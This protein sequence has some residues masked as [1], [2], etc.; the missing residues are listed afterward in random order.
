M[1]MDTQAGF[2]APDTVAGFGSHAPVTVLK[3]ERGITYLIGPDGKRVYLM[4]ST[5]GYNPA[6]HKI[7][8]NPNTPH[9][10]LISDYEWDTATGTFK[11]KTN[12]GNVIALG[13]GA[14]IAAPVAM[15]AFGAGA[16]SSAAASGAL[17]STSI[18]A[19][20]TMSAVAPAITGT[21]AAAAGT[22]AGAG[23][24]AAA[25]VGAG[26]MAGLNARDWLDLALFGGKTVADFAGANMTA[27]ASDKASEAQ[28]QAAREGLAL[29]KQEYD[30][31][32]SDMAPYRDMGS[33]AMAQLGAALGNSHPPT[34]PASTAAVIGG[35]TM[36]NFGTR[37]P[38]PTLNGTGSSRPAGTVGLPSNERIP[39]VAV[40]M[41]ASTPP[42]NNMATFGG[43]TTP[44]M[45]P[46]SNTPTPGAAGTV[47]MVSPDGKEQTMV[48]AAMVPFYEARGARR[49]A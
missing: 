6:T 11:R 13:T 35:P 33:A 22:A 45:T 34:M 14:A 39:G 30:Q 1:A 2:P 17:P 27:N 20:A 3:D 12:W 18:P 5:G 49:A 9:A 46:A 23:A 24:G 8:K 19:A 47:A 37:T 21:S 42:P 38:V 41:P 40:P 31:N 28:L 26:T 4:P 36:A 29:L 48:P 32:R 44:T 7:E 43:P 25:G 16:A 10:G 15:S